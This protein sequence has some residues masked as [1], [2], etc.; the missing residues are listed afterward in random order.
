[1]K[2]PDNITTIGKGAFAGCRIKSLDLNN[3]EVIEEGAFA[4]CFSPWS[5]GATYTLDLPATITSIQD[6][7]F[8]NNR[9]ITDIQFNSKPNI[10]SSA[11]DIYGEV[12]LKF[13]LQRVDYSK[14]YPHYFKHKNAAR[15]PL[16][17]PV[18]LWDHKR[19]G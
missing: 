14:G 4:S 17:A 8:F 18:F 5:K 1:M 15:L 16:F 11:F 9:I 2:I 13:I 6:N 3:V 10:S 7:A 12:D 19:S